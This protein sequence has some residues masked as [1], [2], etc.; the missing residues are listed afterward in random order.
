GLPHITAG[1]SQQ[2][3]EKVI[4]NVKRRLMIFL[5]KAFI[6][7]YI[8]EM[9]RKTVTFM[10]QR[11]DRLKTKPFPDSVSAGVVE[12]GQRNCKN[13]VRFQNVLE[14]LRGSYLIHLINTYE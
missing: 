9:H 2:F 4:E 1:N 5:G 3:L 14:T 13:A 11:M 8:F 7:F 12:T 6:P 10:G